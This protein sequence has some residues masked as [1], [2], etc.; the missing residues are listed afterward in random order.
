MTTATTRAVVAFVVVV[1]VVAAVQYVRRCLG[2]LG[3]TPDGQLR[4]LTRAG[5]TAVIVC[6]IPVGGLLFLGFGRDG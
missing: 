1:I 2:V 3:D 5:W 6:V 4:Y